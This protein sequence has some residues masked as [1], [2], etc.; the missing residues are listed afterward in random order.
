MRGFSLYLGICLLL[1]SPDSGQLSLVKPFLIEVVGSA[2]RKPNPSEGPQ[3]YLIPL[4]MGVSSS[5]SVRRCRT[6]LLMSD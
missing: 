5:M 1:D 3:R 2:S 4:K 6:D